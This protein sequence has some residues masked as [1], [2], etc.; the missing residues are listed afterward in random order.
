MDF[1][2]SWLA[3]GSEMDFPV[4][5]LGSSIADNAGGFADLLSPDNIG[6]YGDFF[7]PAP[8]VDY[9]AL[10]GMSLEGALP[11][12]GQG[13]GV[14]D[15]GPD[16]PG[17]V[18]G[19]LSNPN[20][21]QSIMKGLGLEDPSKA[22]FSNPKTLDSWMRAILGGTNALYALTRGNQAPAG[23]KTPAEVKASLA[24][25]FE[26]FSP[27]QQAWA[28]KYFNTSPTVGQNRPRLD[29]SAMRSPIVPSRGYAQGGALRHIQ[30]DTGGQDDLV[31]ANLSPG[32]YV[33]DADVVSALG[34]G[35]NAAGAKV[36]DAV[37]ENLREHK[38]SAPAHRIPPKAK[39]FASYMPKG[40]LSSLKGPK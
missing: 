32:E 6:S 28:D 7:G 2:L 35:N 27:T 33:F 3:D 11:S 25:G 40:A 5:D 16:G 18:G 22:D 36:L 26:K 23:Y 24:S 38:R 9:S 19:V 1:D 4:G 29:A 21:M 37:R 14:G 20:I 12:A 30:G 17:K 13:A 31:P 15:W 10:N 8:E 39:E 34:D